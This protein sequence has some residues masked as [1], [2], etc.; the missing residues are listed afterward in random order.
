[1][2]VPVAAAHA[3][4]LVT[5]LQTT[6]RPVG[7]GVAPAGSPPY[8]ILWDLPGGALDGPVGDPNADLDM[9][10]QVTCVGRVADEARRMADKVRLALLTSAVV[11][12]GRAVMRVAPDG[13]L[14]SVE[15]DDDTGGPPLWYCAPRFRLLTTPA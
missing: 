3:A 9:P 10:F 12:S 5:V 6:G 13:G 8:S 1:M 15:R 7:D 11:V 4:A 14:G 2:T